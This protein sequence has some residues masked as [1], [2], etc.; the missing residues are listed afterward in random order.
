MKRLAIIFV[1]NLVLINLANAQNVNKYAN[2]EIIVKFK[3]SSVYS[4]ANATTSLE[5]GNIRIDSLGSIYNISNIKITGNRDHLNTYLIKF[6]EHQNIEELTSTYMSTHQFEYVEPNY[7]GEGGGKKAEFLNNPSDTYFARQWGLLNDGSFSL[8]PATIDADIDM[9]QA[10]ELIEHQGTPITIAI[11]DGGAKLDHPEFNN[12]I[13]T[14]ENETVNNSDNDANGYVD[15]VRGWNF[16]YSDNNPVDNHGHG[17]NVTGIIGANGNNDLGYAGIDWNSKLMICKIL[18]EDNT[19][20][21]SWWVDAIYYAVDNGAK[22]INMSVGG[23]NYSNAMKEAV[24]YAYDNDVVVVASMM[25]YNNNAKYYP[26]GYE[27]TIAVGSTDPDD[28]RSVPFFWSQTSGSNYGDHID[29]VAPGNYIYGLKCNSNTNFNS[30]WG[31]TSQAAPHVSGLCALL[32]TYDPELSADSVRSI[33]C[34]T[35][36]DQVG[37]EM[38]DTYGFDIYYGHGRINAYQALLRT[39]VAVNEVIKKD[40]IYLYPNPARDHIYLNPGSDN[41][42]GIEIVNINAQ[43]VKTIVIPE[44]DRNILHIPISALKPGMYFLRV[45]TNDNEIITRKFIKCE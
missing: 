14:N 41:I 24:N 11:L 27:N 8:A 43:S 42:K 31:G 6:S 18:N 17:T 21:Y 12:R 32:L 10:W 39:P 34:T 29:V 9:D 30:Y 38:E 20:Y 3:S 25:N 4:P 40:E 19:G 16:A 23:Q 44:I 13:W 2:D 26:A 35:A 7:I 36:E 45:S 33:I 15:D 37:N 1:I 5:F 28:E 22:V